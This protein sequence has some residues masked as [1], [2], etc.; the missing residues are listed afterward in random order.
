MSQV[1]EEKL[2]S[3]LPE[4]ER[5]KITRIKQQA[6]PKDIQEAELSIK[7]WQEIVSSTDIKLNEVRTTHSLLFSGYSQQFND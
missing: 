5:N 4:K 3:L 2:L 1:V 7:E 6:T